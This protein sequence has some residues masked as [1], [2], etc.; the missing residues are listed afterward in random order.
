MSRRSERA[1]T[2]KR[3]R[4]LPKNALAWKGTGLPAACAAVYDAARVVS[5]P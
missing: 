3:E 4:E 2:T 1:T 5:T